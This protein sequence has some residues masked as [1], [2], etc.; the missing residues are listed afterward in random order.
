MAI[1]DYIMVQ[2]QV[3]TKT[4]GVY[5]FVNSMWDIYFNHVMVLRIIIMLNL[6]IDN[7]SIHFHF[8]ESVGVKYK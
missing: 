2:F 6:M 8:H 7:H 4:V 1:L 3:C 5:I